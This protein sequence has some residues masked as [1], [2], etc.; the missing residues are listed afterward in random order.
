MEIINK[1]EGEDLC[2]GDLQVGDCFMFEGSSSNNVYRV[3]DIDIEDLS[4]DT[5]VK[6]YNFSHNSSVL[7]YDLNVEVKKVKTELI[8]KEDD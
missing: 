4:D 3:V 2:L 5:F 1:V 6:L 8:I 7:R